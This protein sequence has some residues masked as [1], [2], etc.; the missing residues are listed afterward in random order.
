MATFTGTEK[1][2]N[3][4]VGPRMRNK[5]QSL[6]KSAKN[7]ANNTCQLCKKKVDEIE[8]AHVHGRER[9]DII[10]SILDEYRDGDLYNVDL[11]AFEQKFVKAHNPVEETFLFL[12]KDCHTAYDSQ[13]EHTSRPMM[14]HNTN[15]YPKVHTADANDCSKQLNAFPPKNKHVLNESELSKQFKEYLSSAASPRTGRKYSQNTING[16][17]WG[18]KV[19]CD[20][21]GC[22]WK[23]VAPQIDALVF[24][25]GTGGEKAEIGE[26]GRSTVI[27]ALR[28]YRRFTSSPLFT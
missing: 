14:K 11:Q 28:A 1:E 5:V 7:A 16:Y 26:K 10:H 3:T 2:F 12:C 13:T 9:K 4:F 27:N 24:R 21:E 20:E 15:S 23:D 17:T 22:E 18:I 19:V 25:Y 8:A 6:T